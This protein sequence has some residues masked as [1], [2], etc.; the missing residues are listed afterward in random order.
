MYRTPKVRFLLFN[1]WG[2]FQAGQSCITGGPQAY[3]ICATGGSII[4]GFVVYGL[5]LPK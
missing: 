1:F 2:A 3:L 4:G 5:R